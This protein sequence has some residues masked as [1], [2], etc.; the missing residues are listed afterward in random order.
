MAIGK[1]KRFEIFKRDG[2]RCQYCGRTSAEVVLEVD[3]I[4]PRAKGGDDDDI[5]LITAC[6]DCNRGKRDR[7]LGDIHPRPDADLE[8]LRVQQ[9]IAE[10]R[11]Y[12]EAKRI[13]RDAE[14][15]L[16][17]SLCDTWT[18]YLTPN[19][20]PTDQ[21]WRAWL[22]RYSADEIDVAIRKASPKY[23]GGQFGNDEQRAIYQLNRYVTGIMRS[24]RNEAQQVDSIFAASDVPLA[25]RVKKTFEQLVADINAYLMNDPV[26]D[27]FSSALKVF[28]GQ[29]CDLIEEED[30][31]N[32]K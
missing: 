2:F 20:T 30:F 8:F 15:E 23:Q 7:R 22:A 1:T 26:T 31:L 32:Q 18:D 3:H 24:I 9:E 13:K 27:E 4:D 14:I 10:A 29:L 19:Y 6:F 11:R 21:Q 5:N 16:M 17:A 25:G 12:L 28:Y